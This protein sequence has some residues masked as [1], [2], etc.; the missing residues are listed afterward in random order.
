[1]I[2]ITWCHL[3]MFSC[4]C[5]T[6]AARLQAGPPP[7]EQSSEGSAGLSIGSLLS[8]SRILHLQEYQYVQHISTNAALNT[9]LKKS[10][11]PICVMVII[12]EFTKRAQAGCVA[13]LDAS[14]A[15]SC[16]VMSDWPQL[17]R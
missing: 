16:R 13:R 2:F 6:R 15:D 1:M 3:Q 10:Q 8:K 7:Q 5:L 9:L 14:L 4:R 17:S 12:I 11:G